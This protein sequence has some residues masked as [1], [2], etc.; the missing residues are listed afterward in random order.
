MQLLWASPSVILS[1]PLLVQSHAV[2]PF[3]TG[4]HAVTQLSVLCREISLIQ[5]QFSTQFMKLEHSKSAMYR[6]VPLFQVFF[7]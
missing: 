2:R 5:R 7:M 4:R 3:H 1:L 6:D